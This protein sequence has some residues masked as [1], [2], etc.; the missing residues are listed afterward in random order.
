MIYAQ[1]YPFATL[2]LYTRWQW[3]VLCCKYLDTCCEYLDTT[4]VHYAIWKSGSRQIN[5]MWINFLCKECK[6]N[7]VVKFV[8]HLFVSTSGWR[9]ID[10]HEGF[11]D[12]LFFH[13]FKHKVIVCYWEHVHILY[14]YTCHERRIAKKYTY[15]FINH[16]HMRPLTYKNVYAWSTT[17]CHVCIWRTCLLYNEMKIPQVWLILVFCRI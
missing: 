6:H 5:F 14:K 10:L 3:P 9:Q 1:K 8:I 16:Y 11:V 2:I 7:C 13:M 12:E 15:M 17:T 4:N